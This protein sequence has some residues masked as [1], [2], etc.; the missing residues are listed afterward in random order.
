M[1][2]VFPIVRFPDDKGFA[3]F[4]VYLPNS[5][6]FIGHDEV[7]ISIALGYVSQLLILLHTFL[8]IP[9]RYKINYFAHNPTIYDHLNDKIS[10]NVRHL[11]LYSKSGTNELYFKYGVFLLNKNIA[12]LKQ[13]LGLKTNDLRATL[14]NSV[15]AIA[16]LSL[17]LQPPISSSDN[18]SNNNQLN[19]ENVNS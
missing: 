1:P 9:L 11:P 14:P 2:S 8:D 7:M 18:P 6:D 19:S 17:P 15:G 4:D 16:H 3:I 10:D 13:Y 5:E 12:Q